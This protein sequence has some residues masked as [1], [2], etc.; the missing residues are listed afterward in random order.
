MKYTVQGHSL[1]YYVAFVGG[2]K[3]FKFLVDRG[4]NIHSARMV[5][6]NKKNKNKLTLFF[7]SS[8]A[9]NRPRYTRRSA[10]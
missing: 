3:C 8:W 2:E 6:L 7:R 4:A 5:L 1:A 9:P 10:H